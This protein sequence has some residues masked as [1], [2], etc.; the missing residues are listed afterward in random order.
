MSPKIKTSLIAAAALTAI[1]GASA[2]H[3]QADKST[4]DGTMHGAPGNMMQG[5]AEG[6]MNMMPMMR[7]M[8]QMMENCNRM[9]Q[10]MSFHGTDKPNADKTK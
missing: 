5:G 4:G 9:M 7:Q 6:M 8:T 2:L 10:R 1:A 3:A